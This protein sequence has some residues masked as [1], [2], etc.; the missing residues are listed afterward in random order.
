[1]LQR[2]P[3]RKSDAGSSRRAGS[4]F[5]HWLRNGSTFNFG[6]NNP[7]NDSLGTVNTA[8][9][10]YASI[11]QQP[12]EVGGELEGRHE[13]DTVTVEAFHHQDIPISWLQPLWRPCG[14]RPVSQLGRPGMGGSH[15]RFSPWKCNILFQFNQRSH[16]FGVVIQ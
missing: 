4:F 6:I 14:A 15:P 13:Q 5:S 3:S 2:S 9:P 12:S 1:M 7:S 11:Y 10:E 8:L 16:V